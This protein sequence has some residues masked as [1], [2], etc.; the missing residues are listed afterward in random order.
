MD[1]F[2]VKDG[3]ADEGWVEDVGDLI[4]VKGL[5]GVDNDVLKVDDG[6]LGDE[7]ELDFPSEED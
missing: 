1:S 4:V 5:S 3:A 6:R 2:L 7:T